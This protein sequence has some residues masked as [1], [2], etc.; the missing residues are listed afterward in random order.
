M[1][2]AVITHK[3]GTTNA[4]GA[5]T[6]AGDTTGASLIVIAVATIFNAT[7]TPTDL[8]NGSASGNTWTPLTAYAD[9]GTSF[10]RLYYCVNPNTSSTHTFSVSSGSGIYPSI[11]MIAFSGTDTSTPF[12]VQ[13]GASHSSGTTLATGSVTPSKALSV[14][15]TAFATFTSNVSS[16]DS[17]FTISDSQTFQG[18]NHSG[19]A[20]AYKIQSG[21]ATA[22]NPTW[23]E[24]S[25]NSGCAAIA[26][27][28]PASTTTGAPLALLLTEDE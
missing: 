4:N 24:S 21:S 18:A 5:T 23:T 17:S 19:G 14:F 10:V 25:S 15:V 6:A 16:I 8:L 27:F 7:P 12:D 2:I 3:T 11:F 28:K 9:G 13:N 22:E 20:M 1:G 26:I